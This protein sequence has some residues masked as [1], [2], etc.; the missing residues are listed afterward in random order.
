MSEETQRGQLPS[1]V[2]LT[3]I[4]TNYNL[5]VFKDSQMY[6]LKVMASGKE[7]RKLGAF[8]RISRRLSDVVMTILDGQVDSIEN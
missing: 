1:S 6:F 3:D 8:T 2:D 7:L 4:S 5:R